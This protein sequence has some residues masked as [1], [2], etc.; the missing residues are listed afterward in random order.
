MITSYT[1]FFRVHHNKI[2]LY[3]YFGFSEDSRKVAK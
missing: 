2:D 1:S 3:T